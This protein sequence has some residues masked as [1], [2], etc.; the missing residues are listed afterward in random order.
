MKK[1]I[2]IED[3]GTIELEGD[4]NISIT[5]KPD[6]ATY[7]IKWEM[8]RPVL[9]EVVRALSDTVVSKELMDIELKNERAEIASKLT[10]FLS[11]DW[12]RRNIF[13]LTDEEIDQIIEQSS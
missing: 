13:K 1:K 6:W 9:D 7:D 4:H 5:F 8:P 2:I 12:I 3:Y 11:H 10:P